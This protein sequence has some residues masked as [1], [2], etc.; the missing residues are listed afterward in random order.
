MNG[1]VE[2]LETAP[3]RKIV[4]RITLG[5]RCAGDVLIC[6]HI[7]P[8]TPSL[9]YHAASIRCHQCR[10]EMNVYLSRML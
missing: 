1:K 5:Y 6:G 8:L 3:L 10:L 2:L 4:Q 9:A 7:V